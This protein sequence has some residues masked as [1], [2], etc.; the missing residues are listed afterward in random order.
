M[1]HDHVIRIYKSFNQMAKLG[2][3][4]L[5]TSITMQGSAFKISQTFI[6]NYFHCHVV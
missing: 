2:S 1:V 3:N 6:F 5:P 4:S